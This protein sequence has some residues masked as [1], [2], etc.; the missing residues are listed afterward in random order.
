[1]ATPRISAF[2]AERV[3]KFLKHIRQGGVWRETAATLVGLRGDTIEHWMRKG[4]E[5]LAKADTEIERTG[6][7][8]KLGKYADFVVA[9]LAAEAELEMEI[10]GVVLKV[11]RGQDEHAR[12]KAAI[13][14]LE[15]K[16]NMRYGRGSQRTDLP[17]AG[18]GQDGE[19]VDS[20]GFVMEQ[21]ARFKRLLD[22][23]EARSAEADAGTS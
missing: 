18:D 23:A 7:M 19:P 1:M 16:N 11:A 5:Q 10:V 22:T 13:W 9:V 12:L 17:H 8:P 15:R 2:T 3:G 6:R 20:S 14:Y 21:L 4:R